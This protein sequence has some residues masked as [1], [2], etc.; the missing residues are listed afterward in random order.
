MDKSVNRDVAARL[1]EAADILEQQGANPF[2]VRAYRRAEE[3]V[4][5]LGEDLSALMERGGLEALVALR[6][7][8]Q[9]IATAIAE[10]LATGRWAQLERLRGSLDPVKR[11]Q[12]VPGI[13]PKL[14]ERIHEELHVD[15]LEGLELAA[16]DGRLDE[17][18]GV[19][20]R[21]ATTIAATLEKMLGR[22]RRPLHMTVSD[23]P[24]IDKLLD[25]DREYREKATAGELPTITPKRFN[26]LNEAWLPVLHTGREGWHFTVLFSNTARAHDLGRTRDWVVIYFYNDREEEG[27]HTVVTETRGP[28][29]GRRVVRGRESECRAL[30]DA[31][32]GMKA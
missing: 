29:V 7:I 28:L 15:T 11:L 1:R 22:V 18:P 14:A 32:L 16:H 20:S 9:G 19:G 6:G 31:N 12:V 27:Q 21:R 13:G 10:I 3:T 2:R 4:A 30:Y 8:G 17:L 26:P 24:G 23:G 25:V 5:H